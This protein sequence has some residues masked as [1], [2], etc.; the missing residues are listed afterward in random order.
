MVRVLAGDLAIALLCCLLVKTPHSVLLSL[1]LQLTQ[2][3]IV[4][5]RMLVVE[6][7]RVKFCI[8]VLI[9]RL[10]VHMLKVLL[11]HVGTLVRLRVLLLLTW[12]KTSE[13]LIRIG[14][15]WWALCLIM[16]HMC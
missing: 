6:R 13:V 2:M 4:R 1:V 11:L 16:L 5:V 15:R 3:V 8:V 14:S 12:V 10:L 9:R 7:E